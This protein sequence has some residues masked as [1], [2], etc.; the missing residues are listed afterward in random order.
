MEQKCAVLFPV[1]R[2]TVL[3]LRDMKKYGPY[4]VGISFGGCTRTSA[5]VDGSAA[6]LVVKYSA[7]FEFRNI[8][9]LTEEFWNSAQVEICVSRKKWFGG[10]KLV[11]KSAFPLHF[12]RMAA[13]TEWIP[14]QYN[15][16]ERGKAKVRLE[17]M[18][19]PI[20]AL[21]ATVIPPRLGPPKLL[22]DEQVV[23]VAQDWPR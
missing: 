12:A 9:L 20:P 21:S 16:V 15:G 11:G 14:L 19:F 13:F 6:F 22:D 18:N 3:E 4:S 23:R 8:S 2:V 1:L 7:S 17:C 5:V 10:M